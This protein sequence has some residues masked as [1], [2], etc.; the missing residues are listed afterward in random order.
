[1]VELE[2]LEKVNEKVIEP[3]R[4]ICDPHH[5]LWQR[6]GSK[7][8]LEEFLEDIAGGHNV[9]STVFVECAA[10]FNSDTPPEL[11]PIGETEFVQGIAAMSA[12]GGFG[13]CRVAQ[14]IVGFAD[15]SLGRC[16]KSTLEGHLG[17]APK[18]FKGIRHAT[19]WHSS[20]EI[21]N[22]HSNPSKGLMSSEKFLEGFEI[23]GE[24]DLSFD[25]WCYH[26]QLPEFAQ[27]ARANPDVTIILDHFGGPMGIGP[28]QGKMD[29]VFRRWREEVL[30]LVPLENVFFKLG[31]INMKVNG[32][33]WH[34]RALPPSSDELVEATARYYE[35]CIKEFGSERC[36]FESNFPVDKASVSYDVLWN[37]F[38]KIAWNLEESDKDNLFR[39]TAM[40]VYRL[41]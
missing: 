29:E 22:S 35:V 14:G 1:M 36:M 3:E 9:K 4:E 33:D 28:Y 30:E 19:G 41:E 20:Q 16:V 7:Y 32:F 34:K 37:A 10:M 24:L 26:E 11:A 23:L 21:K 13:N 2:W 6:P 40:R 17:V 39:K 38:K 25:A 8:L 12:S 5:H 15:L 18:R 31:G 27:L